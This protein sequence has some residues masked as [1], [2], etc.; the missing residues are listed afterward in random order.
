MFPS[1]IE[2]CQIWIQ[3]SGRKDFIGL[4]REE[5]Q[6]KRLVL[7]SEHFE[8]NQFNCPK[9]H[10]PKKRTLKWKAVPTIFPVPNPPPSTTPKR[11][12]TFRPSPER[13]KKKRKGP[14]SQGACISVE[15]RTMSGVAY[16]Q[17]LLETTVE[18]V[19]SGQ[20]G[21]KEASRSFNIPYSTLGDKVRGRRPVKAKPKKLLLPEEEKGLVEWVQRHAQRSLPRT[22]ENLK[23]KVKEVLDLRG[24]S[25]KSGDG[26]PGK[27]W[28]LSFRERHPELSLR[29]PQALGK[30]RAP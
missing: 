24:A 22:V 13:P 2:R 25:T 23:A 16:S 27:D 21:L 8:K 26:L 7:C 5:I 9:E 29:T 4:S 10:S 15:Q 28:L 30:E 19:K 12:H 1:D 17:E 3:N 20:I 18:L 6:R 14:E 11:K